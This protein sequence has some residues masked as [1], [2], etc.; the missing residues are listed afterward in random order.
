[1]TRKGRQRLCRTE[2]HGDGSRAQGVQSFSAVTHL[3]QVL[4]AGE[5]IA[6]PDEDEQGRSRLVEQRETRTRHRVR[7]RDADEFYRLH[8]VTSPKARLRSPGDGDS[9]VH[10][11]M[12]GALVLI[13]AGLGEAHLVRITR[14]S[15]C[16]T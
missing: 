16:P 11:G 15:S 8:D 4:L 13:C 3:D 1:M 7:E 6:V 14:R 12:E 2:A 5:S 9:T 10:A